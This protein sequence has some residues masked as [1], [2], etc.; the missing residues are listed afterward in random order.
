MVALKYGIRSVIKHK[1][2]STHIMSLKQVGISPNSTDQVWVEAFSIGMK[3]DLIAEFLADEPLEKWTA[4][5]TEKEMWVL[6]SVGKERA[7]VL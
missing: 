1:G 5:N 3:V 4:K 2:G 6:V 7:V